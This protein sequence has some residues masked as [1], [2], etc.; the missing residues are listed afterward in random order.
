MV[1]ASTM[2][3]GMNVGTAPADVFILLGSNIEKERN[4]PAA[5]ARLSQLAGLDIVAISPTYVTPAIGADGH[6]TGQ[7]SFHNAVIHVRTRYSLDEMRAHLRTVEWEMGRRRT[8]DKFAP[9]PIDLDIAIYDDASSS[10]EGTHFV[11]PE[12]GLFPHVALP[13]ADVAPEWILP[14]TGETLASAACRLANEE[15]EIRRL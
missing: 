1:S 13:L 7:A 6:T 4:V 5:V 2:G 9:R 11:D 14:A 8:A 10:L 15:T 3:N 12:I